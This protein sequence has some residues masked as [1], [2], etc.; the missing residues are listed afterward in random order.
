MGCSQADQR[1]IGLERDESDDTRSK[2]LAKNTKYM[3]EIVCS[4]VITES[5]GIHDISERD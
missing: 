2:Y 1:E 4:E 3:F 5:L